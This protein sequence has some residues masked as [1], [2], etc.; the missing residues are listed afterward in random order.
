M[1]AMR[2]GREVCGNPEAASK[3]EWL[4]TNG[5]GG[6]ASS[7]VPG[8]NTRRYH[9]LLTAATEPP[10]GRVLLLSK[11]EETVVMGGRRY[12]LSSNRY[13]GTIFPEG[14][15]YLREFR[16][17]PFP[18]WVF[19]V[20]GVKIEKRVFMVHGENTTVVEYECSGAAELELRPLV[21]FRDYHA[22][23]HR[24]D[25]ID[26]HF[27]A[28][29]GMAVM[30]P[31]IGLPALYL[32]H[33][34][35]VEAGAGWYFNFE[36]DRER[37]RGLD[38]VED[39]F[40]PLLL[41][42][43]AAAGSVTPVIASTVPHV[44]GEAEGMR[45][46]ELQRRAAI[47]M[48]TN[49]TTQRLTAAAD[50]FLV[51]RGELETVIAGYPWFGDWGRDTMIALPGLTLVTRRYEESRRI[52]LAF[53][54]SMD[55]GMVPNRFP[56]RGEAPE[57][58]S[59]DAT[60]WLFEAARA[61]GEHTGD[62]EFVRERLYG[63]LKE[64]VEWHV[65]GTRY[66]IHVDRDGLLASG[67]EGEQL[68]WMDAKVGD[69]VVTPRRGKPVEIQ[70]LWYN[71]L[72]ALEEMAERFGEGDVANDL[73]ALA[74][75]ARVSFA[76]QFWNGAAG[77]LYDVV[78]GDRRD[79]SIRPTQIFTIS[80]RHRVLGNDGL[81]RRV[82]DVVERELLTPAGLRTLSPA[83]AAYCGRYEGGVASRDGAYHQGTVWPWLMG[84]FVT[85]Y[86]K[87]KGDDARVDEWL[88]AFATQMEA[89]CLGQLPE[90]ADGDAP[91]APRGCVAQA[92]SVGELL[93]VLSG[94][95]R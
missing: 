43:A 71:A 8:L 77:C 31:Y 67:E 49:G 84:P 50:V 56:D 53:A 16:L 48:G 91:H 75:R 68:T 30:R 15:R 7:T 73:G 78:D 44:A 24:N 62:H 18:V 64:A 20:E 10:V 35:A 58:N 93:R 76:A 6:F 38:F 90:I 14:Y 60:L 11:L 52:L 9:G 82:L 2:I 29:G 5:L 23:T 80:L 72:R 28:H 79:G 86:R 32:A 70:A 42:F 36:F 81:A 19:E 34:G 54:E 1:D 46:K 25:A 74:A 51:K 45:K 17:D 33:R 69:R 66:G 61:F 85:A 94:Q 12:E 13:P 41:R 95:G 89:A 21:A 27:E 55:Q 37:E 57:Y 39:L 22:T 47:V 92:W 40:N 26:G 59:V 88:R 87:V 3:L 63:K 65:R 4:E 83:D